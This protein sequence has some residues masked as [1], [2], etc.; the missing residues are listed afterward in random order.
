MVYSNINEFISSNTK[1]PSEAN[2]VD[3]ENTKILN[4]NIISFKMNS[5][6]NIEDL[7]EFPVELTFQHL[8]E[9]GENQRPICS[10]WNYDR[11]TYEGEWKQDGCS[12]KKT[13]K[14]HTTCSCNHLTHF[15]VLMDIRGVYEIVMCCISCA[16]RFY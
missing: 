4:T 14:T 5:D 13:N 11:H 7:K 3:A 16:S 9:L 8:S 12:I 15:A 2:N 6:K 1:S 10:Y